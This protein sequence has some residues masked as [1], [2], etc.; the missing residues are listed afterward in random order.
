MKTAK[1]T[2]EA[3]PDLVEAIVQAIRPVLVIPDAGR[4]DR[5]AL[6][7]DKVRRRLRAGPAPLITPTGLADLSKQAG[8]EGVWLI[9]G[10]SN[11]HLVY[12]ISEVKPPN[13]LPDAHTNISINLEIADTG[14]LLIARLRSDGGESGIESR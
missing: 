2:I 7:P 4:N 6:S 9:R 13:N 5:L 8:A 14:V 3:E 1:I 12:D 11:A 10:A